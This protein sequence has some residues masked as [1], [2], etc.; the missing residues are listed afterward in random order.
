MKAILSGRDVFCVMPTG[1]G[2]SLLYQLPCL[3][4]SGFTIVISPIRSLIQDQVNVLIDLGIKVAYSLDD[5][6]TNM[7]LDIREYLKMSD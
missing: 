2:K 1:G 5:K 6:E 3:V 7:N 4:T